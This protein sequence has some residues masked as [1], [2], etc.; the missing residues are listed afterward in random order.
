MGGTRTHPKATEVNAYAVIIG[1][2]HT[3]ESGKKKSVCS[4]GFRKGIKYLD[5]APRGTANIFNYDLKN[6]PDAVKRKS[7][8]EF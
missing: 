7:K 1:I 6:L 5:R 8:Y 3:L 4:N 2:G